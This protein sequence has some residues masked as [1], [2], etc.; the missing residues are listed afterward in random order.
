MRID[1]ASTKY[2]VIAAILLPAVPPTSARAGGQQV[3]GCTFAVK[4]RCVSGEARVTLTDGR[5]TK[6]EVDVFWCGR[7]GSPGYTCTIDA[8]RGDADSKWSEDGGATIIDNMAPWSTSE[9]DRVKVTAGPE[10]SIDL[11]EAQSLGRCGAGAE[12]PRAIVIPGRK[13]ACRVS[14]GSP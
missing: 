14:L 7:R 13:G 3:H 9:P 11:G 12:L 5:I 8:S 2:L 10:L 4:P 1:T 6:I